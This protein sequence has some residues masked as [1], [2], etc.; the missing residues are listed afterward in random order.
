[1]KKALSLLAFFFLFI[2]ANLFAQGPQ[3]SVV[4][5]NFVCLS[6]GCQPIAQTVTIT[7]SAGTTL[8]GVNI[9][10]Y[11]GYNPNQD[12]LT[13]TPM[14]GISG[15]WSSATGVLTL[16]G[17]ATTAQYELA[18]KSVSYCGKNSSLISGPR[19]IF[20]VL[21][22]L[23]Y[24]PSNNHY[25]QKVSWPSDI[26]W[27]DA[28]T[29][30]AS[31]NYLG[32]QGYLITITSL[33]EN[34]FISQLVNSNTWIGA[35]DEAIEGQW[36]W[37]TGCEGLEN[38]GQGRYFS[39]QQ[40]FNCGASGFGTG[41]P[42]SG[43][44]VNW[45]QY[46]P[47]GC[48]N[49]TENYAHLSLTGQ[50]NDFVD[51]GFVSSY[52]V[53]YGCMP[54]DPVVQTYYS[55]NLYLNDSIKSPTIT[56]NLPICNGSTATLTANGSYSSNAVFSWS[57][58][59]S[60]TGNT[61]STSI[62][63]ISQ[64]LN[65]NYT[66]QINDSACVTSK[67]F[68]LNQSAPV[69]LTLVSKTDVL[70][71]G[72]ATGSIS[73]TGNNGNPVYSFLWNNGQT[74]ATAQNLIAG[75]YTVTVTDAIG[76]TASASYS[77]SEPTALNSNITNTTGVSCQANDGQ[78]T[79]S[80]S[81]GVGPY[82]YLWNNGV[83]SANCTGLSLGN[84]TVTV[85]DNHGCTSIKTGSLSAIPSLTIAANSNPTICIGQSTT[86]SI[87]PSG[88]KTPYS[89]LWSNSAAAPN[90]TVNPIM[91]QNY[92]VTVTDA[93][94]CTATY[95]YSVTVNPPLTNHALGTTGVCSGTP[96]SLNVT[97]GGGNGN[98]TYLWSNGI[99]SAS[100]IVSP[101][102]TTT[103]YITVSDL[104]GTPSKLDSVTITIYDFPV[105]NITTTPSSG[106][107]PLEV[108]FS[109]N[110]TIASGSTYTWDLGNGTLS[111]SSNPIETYSDSG[112]YDISLS[113]TTPQGCTSAD[114]IL[115]AVKSFF[116]PIVD[117]DYSPDKGCMP[118]EVTFSDQSQTTAGSAYNWSFGNG[119]ESS[120]ENPV[121]IYTDSGYYDISL[122]VST[123]EGCTSSDTAFKAITSYSTPVADFSYS[124]LTPTI[125][126][127]PVYFVDHSAGVIDHW[128]W[129]LGDSS[130]TSTDINPVHSFMVEADY[131]IVL[132]V[133]NNYLCS[134][135]IVKT[136]SVKNDFSFFIPKAFSPNE[137]GT[138]DF[139]EMSGFNF[140]E[141]DFKVYNRMGQLMKE[142]TNN[143][144]WD[145]KDRNGNLLPEGVYVYTIKL[146]EN[147][148]KRPHEYQGTITLI[149]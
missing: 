42:V 149:R 51:S 102:S 33:Q 132:I 8:D 141:F 76:C 145:G 60:Y 43:Y 34:N 98:Y 36:R 105:I 28:V 46:E 19:T 85:T 125:M 47:N 142:S 94:N 48:N 26:T 107:M 130:I 120:I 27:H 135:T 16:S 49:G 88:G 136:I 78:A 2:S 81:G 67:T 137:D 62:N 21:G 147:L 53:E 52:I 89:Y 18:I 139:L 57:G 119:E 63:N 101:T 12:S 6:G 4:S 23:L 71:N 99:T 54:N 97:A 56:S 64:S 143:P 3:L 41:T 133:S 123:S 32:M 91:S 79:V 116:V 38:G 146:R 95:T 72:G 39:D 109:N 129:T 128:N 73:T 59:S 70:C 11:T 92:S 110:A 66:V 65:G 7:A 55:I 5:S 127:N 37:V 114:T 106:C 14:F 58:P 93:N 118:L 87:V 1:M 104:C 83:T 30:A 113:I 69:A 25:Y 84:F 20:Y 96:T 126:L 74:T 144:L 10:I 50:W 35:T 148:K 112:H 100:Q 24:N 124:P 86:L 138:N 117:F 131:D 108:A 22:K 82:I 9:Y 61:Q 68:S 44:F 13:F 140:G 31:A 121:E 80:A 75:T 103:Y 134:D 17:V 115:S 90:T 29:A 40:N 45:A 122:T 111:S 77:I 15:S